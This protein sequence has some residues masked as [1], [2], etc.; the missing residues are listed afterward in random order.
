MTED[1]NFILKMQLMS[2]DLSLTPFSKD[3]IGLTY[4]S[5]VRCIPRYLACL[6]YVVVSILTIFLHLI[7][8]WKVR[9]NFYKLTHHLSHFI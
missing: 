6:A 2:E 5:V 3:S 7:S 1:V 4:T 9:S 8:D